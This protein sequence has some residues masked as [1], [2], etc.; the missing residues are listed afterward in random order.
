[1]LEAR[2]M[3]QEVRRE[4]NA[5]RST[6]GEGVKSSIQLARIFF[7]MSSKEKDTRGQAVE[8]GR[9]A[10]DELLGRGSRY[11]E[12]VEE[13]SDGRIRMGKKTRTNVRSAKI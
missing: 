3:L 7:D 9:E 2:G 4:R 8:G 12:A 1:M 6:E 13:S 10:G 11:E 5:A